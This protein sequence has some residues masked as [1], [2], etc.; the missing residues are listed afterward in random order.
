MALGV[1]GY[2]AYGYAIFAFAVETNAL[3]LV[4]YAVLGLSTWALLLTLVEHAPGSGDTPRIGLPRR[5]TALFLVAVAG[6]F[7]VMWIGEIAAAIATGVAAPAVAAL[8]LA[9][10]PVWAIDLAVA[11][12]LF[13]LAGVLLLRR[14]ADAERLAIPVLVFIAVM[15]ASI[16]AIFAFDVR[17]GASVPLPAVAIIGATV[18]ISAALVGA[19]WR[20]DRVA[21]SA[22]AR[23]PQPG[24]G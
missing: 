13:V 6:L 14:A 22:A 7:A 21:A 23:T 8:G 10:N 3:S 4:H 19:A 17:A 5:T 18:A 2:L 24:V 20:R 1:L 15:G 9:T 12:P 11:L 16:L